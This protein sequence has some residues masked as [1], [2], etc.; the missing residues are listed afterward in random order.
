MESPRLKGA[1]FEYIQQ[2]RKYREEITDDSSNCVLNIP[3]SRGKRI[4]V[5]HAGNENG[6]ILGT[7]LFSAKNFTNYSADYHQDKDGIL[8]ETWFQHQLLPNVPR[9]S[10]SVMDNARQFLHSRQISKKPNQNTKIRYSS[11]HAC[12]SN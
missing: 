11:L 1:R 9:N 10:V 12:Q 5:L 3:P 6:W 2:I 4:I 7:L 8:F